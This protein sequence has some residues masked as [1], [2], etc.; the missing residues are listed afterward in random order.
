MIDSALKDQIEKIIK[1]TLAEKEKNKQNIDKTIPL[2]A[3]GR[4]IH[5]CQEDIDKEFPHF[6][7]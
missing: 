1:N 5:L 3:S 2:E 4:H 7:K 6:L